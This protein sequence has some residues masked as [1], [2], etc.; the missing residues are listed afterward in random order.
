MST[1]ERRCRLP[2]RAYPASYRR[3]R[4]EEIISTLLDA[5]PEGRS[6]P[7]SRDVRALVI[8]GLRTRAAGTRQRTPAAR[9]RE[10]VLVGIVASL[11]TQIP[12]TV[13]MVVHYEQSLGTAAMFSAF[14]WP[15][16]Y[17]GP[18]ML[19]AAVLSWASRSRLVVLAGV[20]AAAA[21]VLYDGSLPVHDIGSTVTDLI[22]LATLGVVGSWRD[23]PSARWLL[24]LGLV[25]VIWSLPQVHG[26]SHV[27]IAL[28][29][30]GALALCAL[31]LVYL[32]IDAR[33]AIAV[34]VCVLAMLLPFSLDSIGPGFSPLA[35]LLEL[36]IGT[37][38]AGAFW[39][40]RRESAP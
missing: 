27:W 5:T 8:G 37:L 10:A 35:G 16:Y 39:R 2:L 11:L 20:L 9:L 17:I 22:C 4:G 6:W 25:I 3:E 24:P 36:I 14:V 29:A 33:A 32:I 1:L 13:V 23:R 38:G 28:F 12:F 34:T 19:A 15:G 30:G 7:S 21:V 26:G 18:I 31:S 40:L